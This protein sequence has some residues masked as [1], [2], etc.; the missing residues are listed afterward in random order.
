V[1]NSNFLVSFTT[2]EGV[3]AHASA[4]SRP[5]FAAPALDPYDPDQDEED[6][7]V[8][9]ISSLDLMWLTMV[10]LSVVPPSGPMQQGL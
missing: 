10:S 7:L 9:D 1:N 6:T 3:R 4:P 5:G 2:V 8:D